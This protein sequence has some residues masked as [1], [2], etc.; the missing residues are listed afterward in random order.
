[1]ESLIKILTMK[2]GKTIPSGNEAKTIFIEKKFF[3]SPFRYPTSSR[4]TSHLSKKVPYLSDHSSMTTL[5]CK[6]LVP[7][8]IFKGRFF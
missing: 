4:E 8:L 5:C 6:K 2:L 3:L 7:F 1:M